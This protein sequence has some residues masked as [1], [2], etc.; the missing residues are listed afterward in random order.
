HPCEC[1][2]CQQHPRHLVDET[3]DFLILNFFF[4]CLY[5]YRKLF[6]T[7]H[8]DTSS[9]KKELRQSK[10]RATLSV[11]RCYE[12]NKYFSI[13]VLLAFL[14]IFNALQAILVVFLSV[15]N[16]SDSFIVST[17]RRV[18]RFH[19]AFDVLQRL[20]QRLLTL[21]KCVEE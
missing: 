14:S 21:H 12:R 16:I 11:N 18:Q 15:L 5:V 3:T 17:H 6:A 19:F 7:F 10:R 9:L 4:N 13:M 8:L 20:P 1:R 2:E